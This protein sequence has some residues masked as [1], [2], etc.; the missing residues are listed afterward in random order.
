MTR[1]AESASL[2]VALA[3]VLAGSATACRPGTP[4]SGLAEQVATARTADDHAAIAAAF[5]AKADAY[6]AAAGDHGQLAA[7]YATLETFPWQRQHDLLRLADHCHRAG[8][9][10]AAAAADPRELGREH[11]KVAQKLRK[12]QEGVP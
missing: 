5:T 7:A 2:L 6:A 11:Q 9:S 4:P 1:S 3:L 12:E 10:L 8:E